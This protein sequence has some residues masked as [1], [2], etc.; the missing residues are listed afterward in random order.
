MVAVTHECDYPAEAV[1]RLPRVTSNA[2]P[3]DGTTSREID[4]HIRSARHAG[5]SIYNLDAAA[6]MRIEPDLIV[7]QELCDVC[8]VAYETVVRAVRLL[9][10]PV[11]IV[12]LEPATLDEIVATAG[13][14]GEATGEPN[15]GSAVA[16][17]MRERIAVIAAAAAPEPRPRVVCI[18][19]T[20]PIFIGGHWV[21]EMVRI[22]GGNDVLG[23]AG[24]P[25]ADIPWHH[26]LEAQPEVLVLMPCGFGLE[27]TLERA[28][29]VSGRPGFAGL[30][31]AQNGRVVAVDG[32][33][34]FNRPGPRIVDGLEILAAAVRAHPGDPL[35]TGAAWVEPGRTV[36]LGTGPASRARS[37]G[38]K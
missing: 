16:A 34:Y 11:P 14:L 20:D 18:E 35:P 7:T 33:S 8:A 26:V 9:P 13:A 37:S 21:P 27:E 5:S 10:G 1:R 38:Q 36:G 32:S 22:A 12:S 3:T 25:S 6:L 28:V 4:T 17:A 19:W 31:C 15:G 30:P 24:Q 23:V 29:E 2:L